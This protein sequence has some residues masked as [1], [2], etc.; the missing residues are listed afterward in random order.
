MGNIVSQEFC[1]GIG[2]KLFLSSLLKP[3]EENLTV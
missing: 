1:S 2:L 3:L